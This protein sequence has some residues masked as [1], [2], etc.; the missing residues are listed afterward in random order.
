MKEIVIGECERRHPA[1]T[2]NV[3]YAV[4][5]DLLIYFHIFF[6]LSWKI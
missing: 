5:Y 6:L 2:M 4:N 3:T 1:V